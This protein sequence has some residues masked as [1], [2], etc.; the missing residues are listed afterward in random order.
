MTKSPL[1]IFMTILLSFL[2]TDRDIKAQGDY[3]DSPRSLSTKPQMC[4]LKA[5]LWSSGIYLDVAPQI[6]GEL[7]EAKV[8][9]S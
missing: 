1:L 7:V 9:W 4:P 8:G 5:W 3:A 6:E 2:F